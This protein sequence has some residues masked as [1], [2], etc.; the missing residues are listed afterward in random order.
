M[1]TKE[2]LKNID[3]ELERQV[4]VFASDEGLEGLFE[5]P[6]EF[7]RYDLTFPQ[8]MDLTYS[9]LTELLMEGLVK[10]EEYSSRESQNPT[11]VIE[12]N[13]IQ[14]ILNNHYNWYPV[15]KPIY[16]IGATEKGIKYLNSLTEEN[17][18]NLRE[19]LFGKK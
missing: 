6:S 3:W 17:C 8:R 12:K 13:E 15:G 5:L 4:M 16:S 18:K 7:A 14:D 10:L 2:W 11:R 9:I 19:R 1:D